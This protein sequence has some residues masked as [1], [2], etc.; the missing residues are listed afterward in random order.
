MGIKLDLLGSA[1]PAPA[2][3]IDRQHAEARQ[4]RWMMEVERALFATVPAAAPGIRPAGASAAQMQTPMPLPAAPA[5]AADSCES[6]ESIGKAGQPRTQRA[7]RSGAAA[8]RTDEANVPSAA[9]TPGE[10]RAER[11]SNPDIALPDMHGKA[12][13]GTHPTTASPHAVT[14]QDGL[15]APMEELQVSDDVRKH[16]DTDAA[17]P[18]ALPV[19]SHHASHSALHQRELGHD[20]SRSQ[21]E[22]SAMAG[23]PSHPALAVRFGGLTS[24]TVGWAVTPDFAPG[25]AQRALAGQALF[26]SQP[27]QEGPIDVRI[28]EELPEAATSPA[29]GEDEQYAESNLHLFQGEDGVQAW[30]RDARLDSEQARSVALALAREFAQQGNPLAAVTINGRRLRTG[31]AATRFELEAPASETP[32]IQPFEQAA[33]AVTGEK[34]S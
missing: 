7:W 6:R 23:M 11:G 26:R 30:I 13:R 22:V 20:I 14:Q 18:M 9:T 31:D 2:A 8:D 10:E 3:S 12:A 4:G 17:A 25:A 28:T 5:V 16:E 1:R 34:Q 29:Q 33:K 19:L 15:P 24:L 32:H 21:G 27:A